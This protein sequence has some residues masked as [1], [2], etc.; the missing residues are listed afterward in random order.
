MRAFAWKQYDKGLLD[1]P[2]VGYLLVK[3]PFVTCPEVL[4]TLDHAIS[5]E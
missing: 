2:V 5:R 4:T 1:S 3:S